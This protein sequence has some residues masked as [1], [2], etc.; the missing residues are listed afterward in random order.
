ML[1]HKTEDLNALVGDAMAFP[2]QALLAVLHR[3]PL[4][5]LVKALD[6]CSEFCF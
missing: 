5:Y 3:S 1:I 4:W 2:A 6:G